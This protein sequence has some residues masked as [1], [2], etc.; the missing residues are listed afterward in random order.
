VSSLGIVLVVVGVLAG[1]IFG[2]GS[3]RTGIDPRM[4]DAEISRRLERRSSLGFPGLMVDAGLL[5][6]VV[7]VG[8]RLL[9]TLL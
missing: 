4:S 5:C 3:S 2:A 9:R 6:L 8:W 1:A 7:G